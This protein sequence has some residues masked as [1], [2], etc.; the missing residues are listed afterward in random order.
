MVDE[1]DIAMMR[2]ALAEAER[3]AARGEVPVGAVVYRDARAA[4][5]DAASWHAQ[6]ESRPGVGVLATGHNVRESEADPTGHAEIIAL[7]AA[8][9]KLGTW[10]LDGCTLAVTLEPCPMCAGALVNARITRLIYGCADPKMGCVHTLHQL[11]TE[12]RFNHR[13]EVEAGILADESAAMLKAFFTARRSP[14]RPHTR[15]KE[16]RP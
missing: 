10:R 6:A 12:P 1:R 5:A 14:M 13:L 2:L 9:Q 11:C 3:A 15:S 7:R 8:A 16:P 4:L